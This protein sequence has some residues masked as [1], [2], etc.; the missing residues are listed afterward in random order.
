MVAA[1]VGAR[2]KAFVA[3]YMPRVWRLYRI[4]LDRYTVLSPK[5][6]TRVFEKI[7]ESNHWGA[8]ESVSGSGSTPEQ[9][10]GLKSVLPN[11]LARHGIRNLLDVPCGDFGWMRDIVP[12]LDS[13]LGGDI[14]PALV[15]RLQVTYG[16]DSV[17]FEVVDLVVQPLPP[18]DAILVRDVLIH[19]SYADI[20]RSLSNLAK[21]D[22]KWLITTTYPQHENRDII[23]GDWRP[24]NLGAAPFELSPPAELID[25]KNT[26]DGEQFS[27]KSLGVWDIEDVRAA[28]TAFKS[29]P[30]RHKQMF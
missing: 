11:V 15:A 29:R 8:S 20:W 13:Y 16:S 26:H 14:V 19:F 12:L 21:S 18:S 17:S 25:E 10:A 3:F 24:I 7:F 1:R 22:T 2:V 23:T 6:R 5:R 27:D 30:S 28:V 9:T 4:L